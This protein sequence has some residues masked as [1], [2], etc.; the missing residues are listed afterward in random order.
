MESLQKHALS[1]LRNS[2][3]FC[4]YGCIRVQIWGPQRNLELWEEAAADLAELWV[5]LVRDAEHGREHGGSKAHGG[6]GAD[7]VA[8]YDDAY[9]SGGLLG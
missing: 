3:C 6:N 9:V 2:P 7:E 4:S 1:Q 8:R 5:A